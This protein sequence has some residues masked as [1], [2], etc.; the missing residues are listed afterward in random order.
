M[1]HTPTPRGPTDRVRRS[2]RNVRATVRCALASLVVCL[3]TGCG[4]E[5]PPPDP[6]SEPAVSFDRP[7]KL[8]E[9]LLEQWVTCKAALRGGGLDPVSLRT[10]S[11]NAA[12]QAVS[13]RTMVTI[14]ETRR[15]ARNVL[16][17]NRM[18]A[19]AY[20]H[21]NLTVAACLELV[22]QTH[23]WEEFQQAA[24]D[25]RK[26]IP[27]VLGLARG[28]MRVKFKDLP[29]EQRK[30]KHAW[31]DRMLKWREK[32]MQRMA[33]YLE[34]MPRPNYELVAKYRDSFEKAP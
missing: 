29:P 9:P 33:D 27:L 34:H 23:N 10:E 20:V 24:G 12:K 13:P 4:V 15:A 30:A 26:Q 32:W 6:S 8:T 1:I 7:I 16:H 2:C 25:Y 22:G 3:A 21:V 5:Q 28:T 31:I 18:K 17:A 19:G 14:F 11:L